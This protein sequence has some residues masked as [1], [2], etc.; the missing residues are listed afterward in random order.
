MAITLYA[1][2]GSALS[3]TS[4]A[5]GHSAGIGADILEVTTA[6]DGAYFRGLAYLSIYTFDG[7]SETLRA[8]NV[9]SIGWVYT[10]NTHTAAVSWTPGAIIDLSAAGAK[11]RIKTLLYAEG[12]DAYGG[13]QHT[14]TEVYT[15]DTG[16]RGVLQTTTVGGLLSLYLTGYAEDYQQAYASSYT[17][18]G[19]QTRI[20]P[21]FAAGASGPAGLKTVNGLAKASVKTVNGLVIASVKSW[22]GLI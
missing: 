18:I 20:S 21:T 5:H 4:A 14:S 12:G 22:E 1:K 6:E 8:S 15:D 10:A 11:L 3:T 17:C 7:S 9:T 19:D 16:G 13:V 2:S